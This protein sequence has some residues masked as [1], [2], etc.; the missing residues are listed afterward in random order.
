MLYVRLCFDK[1]GTA[2]L[3]EQLRADH[4]AYFKPNLLTDAV[5]HLVQAGPL[6]VSDNDDTNLASFM[7]L[8]ATSLD[9]VVRFHDGDPFTKAGL[10]DRVYIHRWDRH[11]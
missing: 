7:I 8:E 6:C 5:P 1:L 3:R 9:E 2:E 10:Y 4:R 11:I